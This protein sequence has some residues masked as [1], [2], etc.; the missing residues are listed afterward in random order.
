VNWKDK[1]AIRILLL[2]ARM[3]ASEPWQKEIDTLASHIQYVAEPKA[4]VV[5]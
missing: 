3:F 2:V 4:E 1:V 5:Q